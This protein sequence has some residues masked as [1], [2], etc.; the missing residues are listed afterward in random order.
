MQDS[1]R[2]VGEAIVVLFDDSTAAQER[3][4]AALGALRQVRYRPQ[5]V[6]ACFRIVRRQRRIG[7]ES[8]LFGATPSGATRVIKN[9]DGRFSLPM[10][11]SPD[12]GYD[13]VW[14]SPGRLTNGEGWSGA[15]PPDRPWHRNAFFVAAYLGAP[16]TFECTVR[17]PQVHLSPESRVA[18][19]TTLDSAALLTT[20]VADLRAN[21]RALASGVFVVDTSRS[22]AGPWSARIVA[23]LRQPAAATAMVTART[24]PRA[25]FGEVVFSGDTAAISATVSQCR[26][27]EGI[28]Y[29]VTSATHRYFRAG[30]HWE[31]ERR[32]SVAVGDGSRCPW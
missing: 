28:L 16:D 7:D 18:L 3:I 12:A 24:T 13:L 23:A 31:P 8:F 5:P 20:I 21:Y 1:A 19:R 26:E 11:A 17:E 2:A 15:P 27:G 4:R 22:S 14:S 10:F 29:S 30:D 25:W 32:R 9:T 6:T